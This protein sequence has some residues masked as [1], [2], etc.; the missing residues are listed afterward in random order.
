M[1]QVNT[2][3]VI[4]AGGPAGLAAAITAGERGLKS[5]ILEKSSTTGGAAN[6]GM[7]PFGVESRVQERAMISLTKEEVFRRFM[8]Y[9]HWQ[10]DANLIHDYIWKSGDTINWLEDMGV[11]FAGAQKNFPDSEATWHVVQPADGSRPGARIPLRLK[12]T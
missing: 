10:A 5:V 7:G 3:V 12:G 6:M 4:I 11:R 2:D 9:V 8:D 1:K